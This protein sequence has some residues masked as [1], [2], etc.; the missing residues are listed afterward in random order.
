MGTV[1]RALN[2][3]RAG[4][5]LEPMREDPAL[6]A[7]S[8]EQAWKMARAGNCF[9]S[10]SPPGCESVAYYPLR[11]FSAEAVGESLTYHVSD[12]RQAEKTRVGVAVVRRGDYL[13]C[14]MQG[15]SG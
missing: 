2:N 5:G 6:M 11:F 9:H 8:L 1:I 14:V 15:T 12:F 10:E 13:Y 3:I 7:S 4:L